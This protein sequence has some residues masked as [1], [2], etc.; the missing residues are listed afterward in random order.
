MQSK[1]LPKGNA[2]RTTTVG[3]STI[4]FFQRAQR[5][6]STVM[7]APLLL[8]LLRPQGP[9]TGWKPTQA[10]W[11]RCCSPRARGACPV[12]KPR[13]APPHCG[14]HQNIAASSDCSAMRQ[15]A[16]GNLS[17]ANGPCGAAEILQ[18]MQQPSAGRITHLAELLHAP[19]RR[20]AHRTLCVTLRR[21]GARRRCAGFLG[22]RRLRAV[23]AL[24]VRNSHVVPE[25]RLR[26]QW[27]AHQI[28]RG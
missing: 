14:L 13:H 15:H 24:A 6:L 2:V 19:S 5:A 22:I 7:K 3:L 8:F 20:E 25:D 4:C 23:A 17:A 27:A 21:R 28:S 1:H 12:S 18:P 11:E 10:L 9:H 16:V 26:S